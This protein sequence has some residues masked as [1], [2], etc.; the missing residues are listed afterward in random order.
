MARKPDSSLLV[1]IPWCDAFVTWYVLKICPVRLSHA[2]EQTP[3]LPCSCMEEFPPCGTYMFTKT[4]TVLNIHESTLN[5]LC[6]TT[7]KKKKKKIKPIS[8]YRSM[9]SEGGK[10]NQTLKRLF[11]FL[12]PLKNFKSQCSVTKHIIPLIKLTLLYTWVVL[13]KDTRASTPW[14]SI[15]AGRFVV[16]TETFLLHR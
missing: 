6:V 14:S 10:K 5:L 1:R 13:P 2:E 4:P 11:F 16:Q 8:R 15:T 3:L 7:Q 9:C 12:P